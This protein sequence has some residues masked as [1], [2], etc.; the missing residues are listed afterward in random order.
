MMIPLPD[1]FVSRMSRQLGKELPDFLHALEQ[2]PL[3]GIRIN[4]FKT[5]DGIEKYTAGKRIPWA[6]NGWLLKDDSLAGSTVFHEAGAFYLQEPAAMLPAEIMDIHPGERVLDLCAAPGGKSTQMALKLRGEGLI[7]CNEPIMKRAQILSRNIERMGI[8][9]SVVTCSYPDQ[10]PLSW[11]GMFDGVLVDAPCSG[12]GM[13]RRDPETR[14]EWTAAQAAGCAQR[15][16]EILH[17]AARFVRPGGRLVYSTCTYNPE[18]NEQNVRRFLEDNPEFFPEPFVL[19]G[20]DGRKGMFLCMPHR[21]PGEGQF[22]AKLRRTGQ[23]KKQR[24][25][26]ILP[27]LSGEEAEV[28]KAS[29]PYLPVPDFKFGSIMIQ[30]P[31]IPD[32]KG[33]RVLRAGLHLGCFKGKNVVP[34]HAAALSIF[35]DRTAPQ[36]EI[37]DGEMSSYIAGSEIERDTEGW[38]LIKYKGI[39][40]GWGKGSDGRIRNH[41]PK[42]LRKGRILAAP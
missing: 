33:V 16:A 14:K 9:N 36:T 27:K 15:Q 12:E 5:F 37:G 28:F 19:G 18:E 22:A 8:P 2:K 17:E 25:C 39:Y 35:A 31:E 26:G 32:L 42:A 38:T 24:L 23:S 34:D 13:F 40:I 3:R 30:I 11:N 29:F 20:A 4:E 41:Y 10:L 7:V 21:L 6:E 1:A